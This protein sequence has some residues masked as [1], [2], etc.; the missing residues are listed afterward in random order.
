MASLLASLVADQA[1]FL[2]Y[3]GMRCYQRRTKLGQIPE[4]AL[5][6][7]QVMH[8]RTEERWIER[9]ELVSDDLERLFWSRLRTAG[10]FVSTRDVSCEWVAHPHQHHKV[11]RENLGGGL[12]PYRSRYQVRHPM[13]FH[14]SSGSY[15]DENAIYARFRNRPARPLAPDGLKILL[16]GELAFNPDRVLALEERGHQLYGLWTENPWWFNTV[17]PLP[18]GHV[19]DL[20]RSNWRGAV[21]ELKPDV[22]YA[23]LNWQA[24]PFAHEVLRA[25]LGIPF[26]WHF[27]EGPWL[28]LEH[29]TWQQMA[30]LHTKSDGQIYSSPELRD[31]FN[32]VVPGGTDHDRSMVLDGDLPK[33]EWFEGAPS[34]RLSEADGEF[35]TVVPG[36]PIGLYPGLLRDLASER[37][38]SP[39]LWG[40]PAWRLEGLDR[41][42]AACSAR[43]PS[44]PFS[45][46]AEPVGD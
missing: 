39:F 22:I 7:V 35:H 43:L 25:D 41:R 37:I 29:G 9:Q 4:L 44:S 6:L 11:V 28:C 42:R 26:I 40:P 17:G 2:A 23:L 10:H 19:Q 32:T 45:R 13:R 31:W 12:N 46:R 16:V 38:H 14:S 8:R 15:V 34:P 36:R 24:V 33:R 27:K 21:K 1:A 18:F 20:P 30:N 5:Q 3:A